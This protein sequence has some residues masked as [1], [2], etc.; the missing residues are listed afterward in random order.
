MLR[1]CIIAVI[2]PYLYGKDKANLGSKVFFLWG[3]LCTVCFVYA[4]FLIWETKGLTL[5]Q[6]DRMMEECGSPRK[7]VGWVPKSTFAQDM[8]M[9]K[10][11][12]PVAIENAQHAGEKAHIAAGTTHVANSAPVPG[13]GMA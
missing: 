4:Y 2:A 5:E 3:S 8:G 13:T 10:D 12:L 9:T 11:G 7:S 1:N 6:V